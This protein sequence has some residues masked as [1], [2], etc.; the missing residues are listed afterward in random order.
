MWRGFYEYIILSQTGYTIIL[1]R[2]TILG[3]ILNPVEV[4][5]RL[6]CNLKISIETS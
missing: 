5:L 1:S 4:V 6:D 3:E 2:G